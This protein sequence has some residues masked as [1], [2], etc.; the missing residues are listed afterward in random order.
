MRRAAGLLVIAATVVAGCGDPN[1]PVV[2]EAT[3]EPMQTPVGERCGEP[4]DALVDLIARGLDV[5]AELDHVRSVTSEGPSGLRF[6]AAELVGDELDEEPPIGT[7]AITG[8]GDVYAVSAIARYHSSW[9]DG[10]R[11]DPPLTMKTDGAEAA[12]LCTDARVP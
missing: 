6:V 9:P 1:E 3:P 12:E 10:T 2:D 5:D 7:W 11:L 8:D 4:D